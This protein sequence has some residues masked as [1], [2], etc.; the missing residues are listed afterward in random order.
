MEGSKM[1]TEFKLSLLFATLLLVISVVSSLRAEP[2]S[3]NV[4][5]ETGISKLDSDLSSLSPTSAPDVFTE[6]AT[7]ITTSSA[8]LNGKVHAKN[9]ETQ[10]WFEYDTTSGRYRRSTP[11]KTISGSGYT[12]ISIDISDLSAEPIYYYRIVAQ[13]E[14][15]I[16]Y[17]RQVTFTPCIDYYEPNDNFAIAYGPLLSG[18]SYNG[19][20]CSPSDI[21]YYKIIL[22]RP[23]R[24]SV[25]LSTP[26]SKR[27][28]L[29]LYDSSH[30][31]VLST[32]DAPMDLNI[33]TLTY[34]ASAEGIYYIQVLSRSGEYDS[35]QTYSLSGTW[36]SSSTGF[37]PVV[38]TVPAEDITSSSATLRGTVNANLVPTMAWFE[39]GTT[40]K[41]YSNATPKQSVTVATDAALSAEIDGLVSGTTY[42]YRITAQNDVGITHGNENTFVTKE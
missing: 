20:I 31:L 17:G 40:S 33:L 26:K 14:A 29:Q 11:K 1:K 10:A 42:F 4:S 9:L 30:D 22:T 19:K 23:G 39:Y 25:S 3:L 35:I 6:A 13:N 24:I 32:Y 41:M 8:T 27:Y 7:D 34:N 15:G 5:R 21:D 18:N 38:S 37:P 12:L 36:Q 2:Q 28:I 16:T